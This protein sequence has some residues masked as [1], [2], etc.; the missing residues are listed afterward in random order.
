MGNLTF[1]VNIL[2]KTDNTLYLGSG[3]ARWI[4]P[5]M[6]TSTDITNAI[7]NLD[8]SQVGSVSGIISAIKQT[9]G[10][11]YVSGS[12]I[13]AG[14]ATKGM[15]LDGGIIKT[16]TYSLNA[17]INQGT[18][19]YLAYY[20]GTNSIGSNLNFQVE[21]EKTY[22]SRT[23]AAANAGILSSKRI[24]ASAF[25]TPNWYIIN[26]SGSSSSIGFLIYGNNVEYG[27]FNLA[28]MGTTSAVGTANLVLGNATASGTANN[29]RGE[30]NIYSSGTAANRIYSMASSNRANPIPDVS[31]WFAMGANAGVATGGKQLMY[32]SSAGVLSASTQS[33]GSGTQPVWLSGGTIVNTTYSLN[34]K[35]NAGTASSIA[36]YSNDTTISQSARAKVAQERAYYGR[37][38]ASGDM[39]LD[40]GSYAIYSNRHETSG[41]FIVNHSG[42]ANSRGFLLY[43]NNAVHGRFYLNDV[44]TSSQTGEAVLALG[45]ST[46]SG[47][48]N[49][50][51]GSI[52]IYSVNTGRT[53]LRMTNTTSNR[54]ATFPD[55]TGTV[56]VGSITSS[57]PSSPSNGYVWLRPI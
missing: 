48:A 15:Y 50:A 6:V 30:I 21:T 13:T 47:T 7:N 33:Q 20:S 34:A 32:L 29:A 46:A 25:E 5:G 51:R 40:L 43:G 44:G 27:R 1:G 37:T 11:I 45:N 19:N 55:V 39:G 16:M 56:M 52:Y 14:S 9:D 3:N 28:G 49:N 8:V 41:Y 4:I 23:I 53:L 18:A 12:S 42:G 54:T 36:Y 38:I 57:T 26:N 22:A 24:Y 10:K 2:P 31:G 17:N 35:V